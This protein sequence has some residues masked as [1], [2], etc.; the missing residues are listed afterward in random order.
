[1]K[2]FLF[3]ITILAI[4]VAAQANLIT[5]SDSIIGLFDL[6]PDRDLVIS[7]FNPALGTLNSVTITFHTALQ[8][9]L[10]FENL[11]R[12]GGNFTVVTNNIMAYVVIGGGICSSGYTDN[13]TYN[14]T[15]GAYDGST[16]YA[17]TSGIE[18]AAL[19]DDDTVP[20]FLNAPDSMAQFIGTGNMTFTTQTFSMMPLGL[21]TNSEAAVNTTGQASVTIEYDYTPVPEPMT[22]AILSFAGLLL[23]KKIA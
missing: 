9:S 6:M 13:Q 2:N 12:F 15:L 4:T 11:K 8:G 22:I 20:F 19:S 3:I 5:Y 1:M 7:Q 10:G 17:G 21:P 14:V 16:D 23:R 18:V